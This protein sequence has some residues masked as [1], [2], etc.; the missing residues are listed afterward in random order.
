MSYIASLELEN[1]R[2]FRKP[3]QFD[4][5]P[6]TILTGPN[7]SGKSSVLKAILLLQQSLAANDLTLLDLTPGPHRLASI[8]SIMSHG[9]DGV[10]T[11]RITLQDCLGDQ[12]Y[13]LFPGQ[14]AVQTNKSQRRA[15]TSPANLPR[16]VQLTFEYEGV[17]LVAF[18]IT[19]GEDQQPFCYA[20]VGDIRREGLVGDEEVEWDDSGVFLNMSYKWLYYALGGNVETVAAAFELSTDGYG[21]EF[22]RQLV[23]DDNH[24]EGTTTHESIDL[25]G[26]VGSMSYEHLPN[27]S[28][29]TSWYRAS[30]RHHT[31]AQLLMAIF[32]ALQEA[33]TNVEYSGAWEEDRKSLYPLGP[34][35]SSISWMLRRQFESGFDSDEMREWLQAFDVADDIQIKQVDENVYSLRFVRDGHTLRPTDIGAGHFRLLPMILH[36]GQQR[37]LA[38]LLLEEPEANLH[39]N[40]QSSLADLFVRLIGKVDQ[41]PPGMARQRWLAM[42]GEAEWPE[43]VDVLRKRLIV[44]THSEYLIRRLQYLVATGKV[45]PSRIVIYYFG[46]DPEADDYI[47]KIEIAE[48]GQLTQDFG[49]GFIDESTNLMMDLY[50]VSSRN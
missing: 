10:T 18:S 23:D 28:S 9:A 2:T 50:R 34:N 25:F 29:G 37:R 4:F 44:E 3:A 30:F 7:S 40:L 24:L 11:F 14:D 5:A 20:T 22:V 36:L 41:E 16:S 27:S 26:I 19:V 39:P 48:T 15:K 33:L 6:L 21:I 8:G 13:Y 49:P 32:D 38:T 12:I 45:D 31:V 35:Q 17:R 43:K 47:R 1:F 42:S 46:A